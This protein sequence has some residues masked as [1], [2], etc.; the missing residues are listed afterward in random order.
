MS[1]RLK[2]L[3]ELASLLS[4]VVGVVSAVL[5]VRSLLRSPSRRG[6][7]PRPLSPPGASALRWGVVLV[8]LGLAGGCVYLLNTRAPS[9]PLLFCL[10]ALLV[11]VAAYQLT[12]IVLGW[13]LRPDRR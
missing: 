12:R 1:D 6:E 4:T 7:D 3:L 2:V 9:G 10:T 8:C 13:F 5:R 11:L